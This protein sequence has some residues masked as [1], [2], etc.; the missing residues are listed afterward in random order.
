VGASSELGGRLPPSSKSTYL[1]LKQPHEVR[2][3]IMG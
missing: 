2:I 3:D 1:Y